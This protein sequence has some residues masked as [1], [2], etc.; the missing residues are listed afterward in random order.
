MEEVFYRICLRHS[1]SSNVSNSN[2][3]QWN[4]NSSTCHKAH[5]RE[6]PLIECVYR[7]MCASDHHFRFRCPSVFSSMH[8]W[9]FWMD[10]FL[11]SLHDKGD[12]R[13][14]GE[15]NPKDVLNSGRLLL[16]A[17]ISPYKL[18]D[19]TPPPPNATQS[20]SK[21]QHGALRKSLL[22]IPKESECRY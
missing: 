22:S 20:P 2:G 19:F 6:S 18:H 3:K 1:S 12:P 8:L 7:H 5:G 17:P 10:Y 4:H 9:R 15:E 16:S 13:V 11:V 21:I 14:K